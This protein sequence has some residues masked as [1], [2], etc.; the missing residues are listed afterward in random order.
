MPRQQGFTDF[1]SFHLGASPQQAGIGNCEIQL[2]AP[3]TRIDQVRGIEEWLR[4]HLGMP[5]V[6]VI[7]YQLLLPGPIR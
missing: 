4:G 3:I 5:Y 2:P 7:N 6:V 1:V